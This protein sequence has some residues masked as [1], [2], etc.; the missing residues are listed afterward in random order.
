[1]AL[2]DTL[3]RIGVVV[4]GSAFLLSLPTSTLSF[5]V[6]G[7]ADAPRFPLSLWFLPGLV[8]GLLVAGDRLAVTYHQIWKFSFTS[9]FLA[10]LFWL[11]GTS[12]S[13]GTN[14][15]LAVGL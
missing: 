15:T 1:M 14:R 8:V 3:E 9:Y 6:Y 5:L 2:P 13:A 11:V 4:V 10:S 7:I 12:E